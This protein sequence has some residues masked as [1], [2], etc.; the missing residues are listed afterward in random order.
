MHQEVS[1]VE[2]APPSRANLKRIISMVCECFPAR[3]GRGRRCC[4]FSGLT[5]PFPIFFRMGYYV[6][7]LP[8][9]KSQQLETPVR[10]VK[11]ERYAAFP[12]RKTEACLGYQK[13]SLFRTRVPNHDVHL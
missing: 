13:E 5:I 10:L 3:I 4:F 1:A 7:E 8:G 6:R 9:K 2:F 11:E 12:C